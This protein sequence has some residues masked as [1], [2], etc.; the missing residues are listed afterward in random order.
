MREATTP[1]E[2]FLTN[3]LIACL[4]VFF[5][6]SATT[7]LV[8]KFI[9]L[10]YIFGAL[11]IVLYLGYLLRIVSNKLVLKINKRYGIYFFL[12]IISILLS[13]SVGYILGLSAP[14]APGWYT[15]ILYLIKAMTFFIFIDL[16]RNRKEIL[17]EAFVLIGT[18]YAIHGIL[19]FLLVGFGFVSGTDFDSSTIVS[20]SYF[21]KDFG[22]LG[23]ARVPILLPFGI[24]YRAHSFFF[25][26]I[27]FGSFLGINI[28]LILL[29]CKKGFKR[30]LL[31]IINGLC[32]LFTLSI[33]AI[34]AALG[35]WLVYSIKTKNIKVFAITLIIL[36]ALTT[37]FY[38]FIGIGHKKGSYENRTHR[39]TSTV[40]VIFKGYGLLGTGRNNEASVTDDGIPSDQWLR[41]W[42]NHGLLGLFSFLL[43]NIYLFLKLKVKTRYFY[44]TFIIIIMFFDMLDNHYY[45]WIAMAILYLSTR[46]TVCDRYETSPI[47]ALRDAKTSEI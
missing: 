1:Y 32:I 37:L 4:I 35:G 20:Y 2:R 31:L 12:F 47:F 17:I 36:L 28:A 13:T 29:F 40:E 44:F 3:K 19:Q 30:N 18:L 11:I 16:Y 8:Y 14:D 26:P 24:F 39:L 46:C 43:M 7:G 9:I 38:N 15:L 22:I 34:I 33:A 25:E 10:K 42:L 45:F 21:Y 6:I 23:W 5:F 27:M 41:I